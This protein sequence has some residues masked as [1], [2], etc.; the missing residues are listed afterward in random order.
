MDNREN[1]INKE[2]NQ[3]NLDKSSEQPKQK[4]IA[5][6]F[7]GITRSL[8]YTYPSIKNNI[9]NPLNENNIDYDIY[10]HT[11]RLSSKYSNKRA[12]E[13]NVKL[14]FNEYTILDP[15][16]IKI[17]N[18]DEIKKIIKLKEY[19][20]QPDP[21]KT[22]YQTLNN[23]ILA[24]YSKNECTKLMM[25]QN[26]KYDY[27]LFI[28]PD[29]KFIT[30]FNINWLKNIDNDPDTTVCIPNFHCFSGLNDRS[31]I[32]NY[33]NA[34]IYGT[35]FD[36][37]LEYSKTKQLHSETFHKNMLKKLIKDINVIKI[38]FYFCR[39]RANGQ[40]SNNDKAL[41]NKYSKNNNNR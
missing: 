21:W 16:I 19:H 32:L 25:K 38:P 35:F 17:D 24:L 5:I 15:D 26:I 33:D 3:L 27:C 29:V 14:N 2:H 1:N 34:I 28:R 39:I 31:A 7:W 22:K 9:L 23:F 40:M 10:M 20:T 11:Y 6:L 36:H 30:K 18:Q 4:R 37:M 41:Y 13:V 8:K 12:K